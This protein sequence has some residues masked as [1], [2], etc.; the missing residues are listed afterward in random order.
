[1]QVLT[2]CGCQDGFVVVNAEGGVVGEGD[3]MGHGTI[4]HLEIGFNRIFKEKMQ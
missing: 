3:G 2:G 1:M 4:N